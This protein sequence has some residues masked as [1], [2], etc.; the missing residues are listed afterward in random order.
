MFL[1]EYWDLWIQFYDDLSD[2]STDIGPLGTSYEHHNVVAI[3][4]RI[5]KRPL[6]GRVADWSDYQ[7][8]ATGSQITWFD[9]SQIQ[10][11]ALPEAGPEEDTDRSRSGYG[12]SRATGSS[13]P[14]GSA[15]GAALV[16]S[17]FAYGASATSTVIQ[18]TTEKS[19]VLPRIGM[20]FEMAPY[21]FV[22]MVAVCMVLAWAYGHGYI[23]VQFEV[24]N[25]G[26]QRENKPMKVESKPNKNENELKADATP[27][28]PKPVAPRPKSSM[29]AKGRGKGKGCSLYQSRP[30]PT[31]ARQTARPKAKASAASSSSRT[32]STRSGSSVGPY[33]RSRPL[34]VAP[35]TGQ[36]Y[37]RN[38]HCD[39]LRNANTVIP[40][41][42]CT[43]CMLRDTLTGRERVSASSLYAAPEHDI[44]YHNSQHCMRLADANRI[45]RFRACNL[46]ADGRRLS[47]DTG[48]PPSPASAA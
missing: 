43:T 42:R 9:P 16:A 20:M 23:K 31:T 21:M 26:Y 14:F 46:C 32:S 36:C 38:E 18:W 4:D 12:Q 17:Q 44:F 5:M 29:P 1:K 8:A 27:P 11:V 45:V 7:W 41:W 30:V 22:M 48:G 40:M 47:S 6:S 25:S 15:T 34:W 3:V 33:V 37:H 24:G 2:P 13:N 19:S 10:N 39:G 28:P 35:Q